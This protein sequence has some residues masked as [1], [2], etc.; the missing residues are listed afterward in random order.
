MVPGIKKT[1]NQ[2]NVDQV[3]AIK[4]KLQTIENYGSGSHAWRS[5]KLT[6]MIHILTILKRLGI[7]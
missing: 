5:V 1:E 7:L 4:E 6:L 3:M 2:E